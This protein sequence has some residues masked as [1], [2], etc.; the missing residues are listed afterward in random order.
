PAPDYGPTVIGLVFAL[1]VL[2]SFLAQ[3]DTAL[4]RGAAE[5]ARILR[6]DWW[7]AVTALTL[8][9]DAAHAGGNALAGAIALSALAHRLGPAP[10]AWLALL[11]GILGNAL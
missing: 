8:H 5:A 11:S 9:I 6:G 7:R 1:L 4:E 10:A 2:A 3:T